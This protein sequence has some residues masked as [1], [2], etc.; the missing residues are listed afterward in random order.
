MVLLFIF[1]EVRG[2]ALTSVVIKV[3]GISI[4]G[5]YVVF[6]LMVDRVGGNQRRKMGNLDMLYS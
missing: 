3:K 1:G 2:L 4:N 5:E 6:A